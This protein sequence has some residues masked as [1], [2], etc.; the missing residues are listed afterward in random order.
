MTYADRV[1]APTLI[2]AGEQD[3]RCPPEGITPWVDAVRARGVPVEVEMYAAGHHANSMEQQV[4]HMRRI[5]A[6]FA[7]YR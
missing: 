6:F 5:L 1:T 2:I 7:R 3:P 4:D